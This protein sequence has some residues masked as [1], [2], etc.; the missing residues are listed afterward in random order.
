MISKNLKD[1]ERIIEKIS[2]G[3]YVALAKKDVC[4]ET[5]FIRSSNKRSLDT[6]FD[7]RLCCSTTFVEL[8]LS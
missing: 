2:C 8:L 5:A 7:A 3:L 6:P 4:V 1:I